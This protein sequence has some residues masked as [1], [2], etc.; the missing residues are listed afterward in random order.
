MIREAGFRDVAL[1]DL[2][3]SFLGTNKETTARKFA[4]MGTNLLAFKP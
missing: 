4:V 1:R 3:D 2:F